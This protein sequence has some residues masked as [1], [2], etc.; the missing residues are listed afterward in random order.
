M[1]VVYR[2]KGGGVRQDGIDAIAELKVFDEMRELLLEIREV[3]NFKSGDPNPRYEI[4]ANVSDFAL[5]QSVL[6]SRVYEE[7]A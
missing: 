3:P 4:V 2:L 1:E 7:E 6:I 5:K